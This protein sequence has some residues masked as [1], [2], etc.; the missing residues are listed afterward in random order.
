MSS[1]KK[2]TCKGTLLHV[3]ITV[4]RLEIQ[5]AMF[6]FCELLPTLTFS[7]I[8]PSP[9]PCV[10][11]CTVYTYTVCKGEGVWGSGPQSDKHMPQSSF[12]GHF[13]RWRHFA[14][15]SMSLIFLWAPHNFCCRHIWLQPLF[16]PPPSFSSYISVAWT[17]M[18]NGEKF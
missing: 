17:K 11:K 1:S 14:L 5:S 12:T 10:S 3:F 4:Y 16:V 7:L 13:F 8:K 2:L 15:P 18:N 6:V 9:L